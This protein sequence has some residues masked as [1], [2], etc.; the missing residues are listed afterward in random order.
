MKKPRSRDDHAA[1]PVLR[2]WVS[3]TAVALVSLAACHPAPRAAD[4]AAHGP[5]DAMSAD[6][7]MEFMRGVV[8]PRMGEIF[9][10]FDRHRYPEL[11]CATCHGSD[12]AERAW[13]M[14]NPDLL[15]EPTP[16]NTG[17]AAPE[18]APTSFDAFMA[19]SVAPEMAKLLDRPSFG[20]FGCHT[21][22]T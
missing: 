4:P 8:T 1:H 9:T 20:C 19:R 16:W 14:P 21:P 2:A 10:G 13:K 17:P 7:K 6:Q 11:R 5:W 15:L 12:G 22:E 3:V 18:H